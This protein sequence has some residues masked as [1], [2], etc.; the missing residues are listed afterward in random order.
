MRRKIIF[1]VALVLCLSLVFSSTSA[2][3]QEY[4]Y[5]EPGT[6]LLWSLLITGGG[7]IYNG[8]IAKGLVMLGAE[9]VALAVMSLSETPE[10]GIAI[11]IPIWSMVD[12][13][14]TAKRLNKERG[15][16]IEFKN[17]GILLAYRIKF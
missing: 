5:R 13:Y 10:I 6:A 11:A 7:Q 17:D 2:L 9:V 14:S 15:L 8:Q 3:A 12:A 1:M 4:K 16:T